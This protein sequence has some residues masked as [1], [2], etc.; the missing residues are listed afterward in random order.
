[1]CLYNF[2]VVSSEFRHRSCIN[3]ASDFTRLCG[4]EVMRHLCNV[5]CF[6]PKGTSIAQTARRTSAKANIAKFQKNTT[7]LDLGAFVEVGALNLER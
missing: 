2:I 5:V 6:A 1:M 4:R 7:E 3:D